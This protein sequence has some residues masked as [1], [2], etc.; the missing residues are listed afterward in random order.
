MSQPVPKRTTYDDAMEAE[1]SR[2]PGVTFKRVIRGKH[3]G[4][5]LSFNGVTR[6]HIYPST[7]SDNGRGALNQIRC[8]K[9][10]LQTIGA[11]R[12]PEPKAKHPKRA[13]NK[14]VSTVIDLGERAV[15]D[16]SR[17]PFTDLTKLRRQ[18]V[19]A[20]P[21]VLPIVNSHRPWWRKLL[22]HSKGQIVLP[23]DRK[24]K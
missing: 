12:L 22:P 20:T 2:W 19:D 6:L 13:R 18:M 21:V 10:S 3:Y 11:Q 8:L 5:Q 16:P 15:R 17:D 24:T 23:N 4:M 14:T 7:P 1:I 9:A